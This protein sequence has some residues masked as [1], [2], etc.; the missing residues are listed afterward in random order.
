MA[1]L[2]DDFMSTRGFAPWLRA[3]IRFWISVE[4]LNRPPTLLTIPSSFK[5]SSIWALSKVGRSPAV[6]RRRPADRRLPVVLLSDLASN[7]PGSISQRWPFLLH[8][9]LLDPPQLPIRYGKLLDGELARLD[10]G[11]ALVLCLYQGQK[12]LFAAFNAFFFE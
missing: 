6:W 8:P 4:S 11:Q 3:T 12:D 2:F 1:M 9:L 10:H 5:S 7:G